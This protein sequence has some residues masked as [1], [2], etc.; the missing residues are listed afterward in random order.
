MEVDRENRNCYNCRGFGH[1]V[2]NCRNGEIED[3][4]GVMIKYL[5]YSAWTR[6]Q[7]DDDMI[8]YAKVI[9]VSALCSRC[10]VLVLSSYF[11]TQLPYVQ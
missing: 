11:I 8:G 3:R 2:K 4:I 5:M 6:V 10:C 1:L 7:G 9:L